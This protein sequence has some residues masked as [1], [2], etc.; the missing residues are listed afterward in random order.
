MPVLI[1]VHGG[2]RCLAETPEVESHGVGSDLRSGDRAAIRPDHIAADTVPAT[3]SPPKLEYI[4]TKLQALGGDF[5]FGFGFFQMCP[6]DGEAVKIRKV[7]E[8]LFH[9][10]W[11]HDCMEALASCGQR[12]VARESQTEGAVLLHTGLG[13]HLRPTDQID[14][15]APEVIRVNL[16]KRA[17]KLDHG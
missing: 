10:G 16:C 6:L 9:S 13:E 14:V 4:F 7:I 5:V 15:N 3:P 12:R 1:R 17:C 8:M 11:A 2:F